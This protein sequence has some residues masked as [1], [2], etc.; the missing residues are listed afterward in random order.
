MEELSLDYMRKATRSIE[1]KYQEF[2]NLR[3]MYKDSRI[4]CFYEGK[5][6]CKY[7]FPKIS[8]YTDKDI[9]DFDCAGK[10]NVY[11][12]HGKI[13]QINLKEEKTL[14]FVDND[15]DEDN[16]VHEDIYCTPCYSIENFYMNKRFFKLFFKY[17]LRIDEYSKNEIDKNDYE[18]LIQLYEY[19]KN[20]FIEDITLLNTWYYLQVNLGKSLPKELRPNLEKIKEIKIDKIPKSI[21]VLKTLTER[22][23]EVT[24]EQIN[25]ISKKLLINP[26]SK[27][28]GKYFEK[29]IASFLSKVVTESNKPTYILS[30]R[31][32][33]KGNISK[34]DIIGDYQQFAYV[35]LN[36]KKYLTNILDEDKYR[37]A[38]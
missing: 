28:R 32:K 17:Q 25:E 13:S 10:D 2:I 37:N 21:E 22:Y 31:R 34:D 5:D 27:F 11:Y 35:P 9:I 3:A 38:M 20:K 29:F 6:D 26:E 4:Y 1:V 19:N 14:F 7:Y 23:I 12:I 33:V 15:F 30:K 24:D 16:I 36:L 8:N 18:A